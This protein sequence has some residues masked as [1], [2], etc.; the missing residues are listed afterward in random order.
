MVDPVIGES[1]PLEVARE[2]RPKSNRRRGNRKNSGTK[3]RTETT[4][5]S[6]PAVNENKKESPRS[7]PRTQRKPRAP[8]VEGDETRE[9]ADYTD[10]VLRL[11]VSSSRPRTVYTRLARLMMAGYDSAGNALEAG[12]AITRVEVSALGNAIGAAI[13]V[14]DNLTKGGVVK[15]VSISADFVNVDGDEVT[16]AEN[17]FKGSARL[18]L[19]LEK[20]ESWEPLSDE[21]L[22]KTRVF[23]SKVLGLPEEEAPAATTE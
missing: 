4:S 9:K 16:S 2:E 20:L 21:V 17:R 6:A 1:T 8:R 22:K 19:S 10:G 18:L 15:Q 23:R 13:F 11:K 12:Q 3:E 14:A 5:D 7:A